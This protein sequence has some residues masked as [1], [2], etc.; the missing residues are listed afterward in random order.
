MEIEEYVPQLER[1]KG[2]CDI[3]KVSDIHSQY[4]Y[5]AKFCRRFDIE[6]LHKSDALSQT[7]KMLRNTH[8]QMFEGVS[9]ICHF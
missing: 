5:S 2:I 6:W 3:K 8:A 7:R 9:S 4:R 1:H